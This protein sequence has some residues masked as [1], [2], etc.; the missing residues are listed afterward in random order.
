MWTGPWTRESL[1]QANPPFGRPTIWATATEAFQSALQPTGRYTQRTVR[2]SGLSSIA[3]SSKVNPERVYSST[4]Q[5]STAPFRGY[6]IRTCV[7]PTQISSK[8]TTVQ[9]MASSAGTC[10]CW[11]VRRMIRSSSSTT[12]SSITCSKSSDKTISRV[13]STGIIRGTPSSQIG[14][15]QK[16][17]CY[18]LKVWWTSTA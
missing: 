9:F 13:S 16:T 15:T 17:R 5:G 11:H 10:L 7:H 8:R 12:V 1:Y 4:T 2:G 3:G 6:A 14:I 18:R